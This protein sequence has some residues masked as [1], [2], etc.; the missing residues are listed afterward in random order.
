MKLALATR[1]PTGGRQQC[2]EAAAIAM[3]AQEI[4]AV[5]IRLIHGVRV[6]PSMLVA[7]PAR[8]TAEIDAGRP[9]Q[10]P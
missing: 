5:H 8:A 9:P 1:D 3:T 2:T 7:H 10:P 6:N 4:A